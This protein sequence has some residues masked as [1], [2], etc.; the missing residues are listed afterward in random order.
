MLVA[1][2]AVAA[3][4]L[5]GSPVPAAAAG[6]SIS[7]VAALRVT[8]GNDFVSTM[9]V[10]NAGPDAA[11]GVEVTDP[12][13]SAIVLASVS[14]DHGAC[15]PGA[16]VVCHLGTIDPGASAVV[17]VQAVSIRPGTFTLTASVASPDDATTEDDA[18]ARVVTATGPVCAIVG[19]TGIDVL[20]GTDDAEVIC[21]LG[22]ADTIDAGSRDRVLAGDGDDLVRTTGRDAVLEGGRGDDRLEGGAYADLL[23]GE[24]GDDTIS[25]GAGDD[26]LDGGSGTNTLA[27]GDGVDTCAHSG[28]SCFLR[29]FDDVR[30][31]GARVD[32]RT[33]RPTF[34]STVTIAIGSWYPWSLAELEERGWFVI[35]FDSLGS[36]AADALAVVRVH[37]GVLSASLFRVTSTTESRVASLVVRRLSSSRISV[38]VPLSRLQRDATRTMYRWGVS[39]LYLTS[40]CP[41]TVCLDDAPGANVLLSQ[42]WP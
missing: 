5:P 30:E 10:T 38:A 33:V 19:T 23:R 13:S 28:S 32:L 11:T 2:F 18:A 17:T 9:T 34:G 25:G 22:G 42:P 26:F 14:T 37:R 39:S 36:G 41:R 7:S 21:G 31:R 1:G 29:S 3:L 12:L 16:T 6:V 35:R 24:S 4:V 40:V 27:G 15:D 8:V 20:V